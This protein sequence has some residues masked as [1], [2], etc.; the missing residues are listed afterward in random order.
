MAG[1]LDFQKDTFINATSMHYVDEFL[2]NSEEQLSLEKIFNRQSEYLPNKFFIDKLFNFVF[3]SE[4]NE[5]VSFIDRI[6]ISVSQNFSVPTISISHNATYLY[7]KELNL[8]E[9]LDSNL[10]WDFLEDAHNQNKVLLRDLLTPDILKLINL[11]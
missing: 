8:S 11:S 9:N 3:Q 10:F 4:V 5:E 2:W 6:A 7:D 1:F